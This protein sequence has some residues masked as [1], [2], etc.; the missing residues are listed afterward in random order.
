MTLAAWVCKLGIMS[1]RFQVVE[2]NPNQ[3][4]GGGGCLCS[5]VENPDCEGPFAV[6]PHTEMSSNISPHPVI[7]LGCAEAVVKQAGKEVLAGGESVAGEYVPAD[8]DVVS[9]THAI[10]VDGEV[11]ERPT[12]AEIA[13]AEV[14]PEV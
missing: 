7:C 13:D 9:V 12:P 11:E 3:T 8:G 6:F 14:I 2:I 10:S 4:T 5:E 1:E